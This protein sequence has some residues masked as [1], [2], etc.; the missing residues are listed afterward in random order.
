MSV[1][2]VPLENTPQTFDVNLAG[3]NYTITCKW[4]DAP[5]GG[6]ALDF[7]DTQTNLP[8]VSYVP[9]ITGANLLVGLEYLGINGQLRAATDGNL[10]IPPTLDNLGVESFLYFQ[11]DE[12]NA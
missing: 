5:E 8:I 11:T 12:D 4:N 1:F 10:D 3:V 2:I 7:V 9:I 6:W